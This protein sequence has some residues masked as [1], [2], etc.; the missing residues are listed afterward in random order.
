MFNCTQILG[1]FCLTAV[2][3]CLLAASASAE[4]PIIATA[5]T[6]GYIGPCENCPE[7]TGFGGL[8]RR[9][10]AIQNWENGSP[11]LLDAGNFLFGSQYPEDQG[12]TMAQAYR[13]MGYQVVN[14]VPAD[15]R[16]GQEIALDRLAT[17]EAQTVSANLY[18]ESGDRIFDAYINLQHAGQSW[19]IIGLSTQPA[20]WE[21]TGVEPHRWPSIQVADPAEVLKSLLPNLPDADR[22]IVLYH[23]SPESFPAVRRSANDRVDLWLV[24]GFRS[25]PSSLKDSV[26]APQR[27]GAAL[28]II[29]PQTSSLAPTETYWLG[30]DHPEQR[31]GK[32]G[33]SLLPPELTL[34]N[35]EVARDSGRI[36]PDFD[37]GS[38]SE[39]DLLTLGDNLGWSIGINGL[40][41]AK[42]FGNQ[43]PSQEESR[44]L[45]LDTVWTNRVPL[46]YPLLLDK[47]EGVQVDDL[48]RQLFLL[49]NRE[50][51]LRPVTEGQLP[52]NALPKGFVVW[53]RGD[54]RRG[55]VAF[56]IASDFDPSELELRFYHNEFPPL[57]IP[58]LGDSAAE[59]VIEDRSPESYQS[60]DVAALVLDHW[61]WVDSWEGNEPAPG[62]RFIS[63]RLRG[64]GLLPYET[65]ALALDPGADPEEMVDNPRVVPYVQP[66]NFLRLVHPQG[67]YYGIHGELTPLSEDWY[68]LPDFYVGYTLV[69]TVPEEASDDLS[70]AAYFPQMATATGGSIGLPDTLRF[71]LSG[72]A[73]PVQP[74]SEALETFQDG[75]IE[76]RLISVDRFA[77]WGEWVAGEDQKLLVFALELTNQSDNNGLFPLGER[78]QIR[79]A[80]KITHSPLAVTDAWGFPVDSQFVLPVNEPVRLHFV[81]PIPDEA[82]SAEMRYGGTET[83]QDLLFQLATETPEVSQ[84]DQASEAEEASPM[85][86]TG[87]DSPEEETVETEPAERDEPGVPASDH[88]DPDLP[89]YLRVETF[90]PFDP[91]LEEFTGSIPVRDNPRIET[92][93][94]LEL[95][96]EKIPSLHIA[97]QSEALDFGEWWMEGWLKHADWI[98]ADDGSYVLQ[99]ENHF[100]PAFLIH[101]EPVEEIEVVGRMGVFDH[102]DDDHIGLVM[103]LQAPLREKGRHIN[104]H[105]YILFSWNQAGKTRLQLR[106]TGRREGME[107]YLV[108]GVDKM[109]E[110]EWE[111]RVNDRD[112]N[113][114]HSPHWRNISTDHL[115]FIPLVEHGEEHELPW[116]PDVL[117][118]V[119]LSY[120]PERIRI[121]VQGGD[122]HFA[123]ERVVFDVSIDD[124]PAEHFPDGRFPTGHFGFYNNSQEMS[125]YE[126]FYR[127]SFPSMDAPA[128]V[129][130]TTP[131]MPVRNYYLIF[132]SSGT[133][134]APMEGQPKYRVVREAI[135]YFV[136]EVPDGSD[137]SLRPFG[138]TKRP[139]EDGANEDSE[140][141]YRTR[142]LDDAA[143]EEISRV[144]ASIQPRGRSVLTYSIERAKRDVGTGRRG[145]PLVI[146]L[147]D[148]ADD[149]GNPTA[150]PVAAVADFGERENVDFAIIGFD[151]TREDWRRR[152]DDMTTASKG[153]FFPADSAEDLQNAIL[154]AGRWTPSTL[155]FFDENGDKV[156][157]LQ[158]EESYEFPPGVY[159]IQE[160]QNGEV[161][162]TTERWL[163]PGMELTIPATIIQD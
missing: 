108:R 84:M 76:T 63:L 4:D 55:L 65:H 134:R 23:G 96:A 61:E 112:R 62:K 64:R 109:T 125:Y 59:S 36:D 17:T 140:L 81:H 80:G 21:E 127:E 68:L 46:A 29:D 75:E 124:V 160:E 60:N 131:P 110:Q 122:Q 43:E 14:V 92:D 102:D 66:G 30:S 54:S 57:G 158:S 156:V 148:G 41:I 120:G 142:S 31:Q 116:E 161:L 129:H 33:V 149:R 3:G 28:S 70:L 77:Q 163:R 162:R 100:M 151:V 144:L 7:G 11:L 39:V 94:E 150:D 9:Y 78:T 16:Y 58:I 2:I 111:R 45:I 44:F 97:D 24:S 135:Q 115:H 85:E 118:S 147:T 49:V 132:D 136:D 101:P 139:I 71:P 105:D 20:P 114:L 42:Q 130:V 22:T 145:N 95:D 50:E 82:T 32:D 87:L 34:D 27:H 99:R 121:A 117:Y 53:T 5:D 133:M 104:Q 19:N 106:R 73:Q 86:I 79:A 138:H 143:R 83:G 26:V 113:H 40:R 159:R 89:D 8:A 25:V 90:V 141:I 152:L 74:A 123:E 52:S 51:L 12:N 128:T 35:I 48:G 137:I 1:K 154:D 88:V 107:L 103:G 10:H 47:P 6:E 146:L 91:L 153:V 98:A 38:E 119:R 15:F 72:N 155:V 126:S 56:E 69:F 157:R 13:S 37:W 93:Y 67:S 18:D